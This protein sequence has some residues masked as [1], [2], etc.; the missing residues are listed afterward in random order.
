MHILQTWLNTLEV[1]SKNHPESL[2]LHINHERPKTQH[3]F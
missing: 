3:F 1:N 2:I